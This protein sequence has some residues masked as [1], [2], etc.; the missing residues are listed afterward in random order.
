VL[1]DREIANLHCPDPGPHQL[2]NLATDGFDHAPHLAVPA[3]ADAH[4]DERIFLG[5]ADALYDGRLRGPVLQHNTL[6]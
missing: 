6:D 5:V 1:P 4:F 2:Q 3:F